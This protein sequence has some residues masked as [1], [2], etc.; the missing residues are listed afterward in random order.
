MT[1]EG[2]K[3]EACL[4][5][6]DLHVTFSLIKNCDRIVYQIVFLTLNLFAPWNGYRCVMNKNWVT[7]TYILW[8]KLN[9]IYM[10]HGM[11]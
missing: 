8:L 7:M 6:V 11:V 2:Q 4:G 1:W 9:Q 5:Y 10:H 3:R